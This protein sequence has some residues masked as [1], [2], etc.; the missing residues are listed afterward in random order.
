MNS[1]TKEFP[2]ELEFAS[3]ESTEF[4]GRHAFERS[5]FLTEIK[6]V[7]QVIALLCRVETARFGIS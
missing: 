3:Q 1:S 7:L 2:S 4:A 5:R 6:A